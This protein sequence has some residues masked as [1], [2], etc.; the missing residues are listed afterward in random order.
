[1]PCH[2]P[3][4]CSIFTRVIYH[5]SHHPLITTI[6]LHTH[7]VS[8]RDHQP[9][10]LPPYSHH[11]HYHHHPTLITTTCPLPNW[12]GHTK[13]SAQWL[14]QVLSPPESSAQ[15]LKQILSDHPSHPNPPTPSLILLHT[16]HYTTLRARQSSSST[17]FQRSRLDTDLHSFNT[18]S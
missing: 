15:W 12:P 10:I 13:S 5:P 7:V 4:H 17:K 2:A 3:V 8:E 14:K 6:L 11:R 18:Q 9:T 1:M 16:L